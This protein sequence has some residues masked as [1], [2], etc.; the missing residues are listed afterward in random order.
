MFSLDEGAT[1]IP[2]GMRPLGTAVG[3]FTGKNVCGT[4][5]LTGTHAM[6]SARVGLPAWSA[7]T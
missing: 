1:W 3:M 6:H 2:G 5:L 7:L 4:L